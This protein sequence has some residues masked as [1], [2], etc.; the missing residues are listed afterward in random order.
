VKNEKIEQTNFM[1][2]QN[3]VVTLYEGH[4]H[5]GVAALIN[6]L[7]ASG[8]RGLVRVGYRGDLPPWTSQLRKIDDSTFALDDDL[9]VSFLK[10][11]PGI[12]FGYYKPT[13]LKD[14]F[15]K[16]PSAQKAYYFDPDIVVIAPWT[17]YTSWTDAGVA[18]CFDNCF[19]FVHRN[20][21]WR[22]DWKNLSGD[23]SSELNPIDYYVNSGFIGMNRSETLILDRWIQFTDNY[24]NIGGDLSLFEKDAHR[25]FKGDQDIL[26]AAITVSPDIRFSVIGSEGMG[27]AYPA[28]LMAHAIGNIKPWKLRFIRQALFKGIKPSLQAK[29]FFI[30]ANYPIRIYGGAAFFYKK[31]SMKIAVFIGRFWGK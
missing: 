17:F 28:Y 30:Y 25:S 14:T 21:P 8:F 31:I 29:S 9:A 2:Y 26:N 16:Y 23:P 19:P 12:H 22:T 11:T 3:I 13:F 1:E 5:Y 7:K 6:S 18:L 15:E 10:L 4:Y 27:F 20:H 24:K